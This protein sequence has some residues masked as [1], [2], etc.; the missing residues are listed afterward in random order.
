M[1]ES[2]IQV[3]PAGG[4][5]NVAGWNQTRAGVLVQ[6]QQV[7]RMDFPVFCFGAITSGGAAL[8]EHLLSLENGASSNVICRVRYLYIYAPDTTAATNEVWQIMIGRGTTPSAGTSKT[9]S[10]LDTRDILDANVTAY[11]NR[12]YGGFGGWGGLYRYL[13]MAH[14]VAASGYASDAYGLASPNLI[15]AWQDSPGF[16]VR[17]GENFSVQLMQIKD[18]A[19]NDISPSGHHARMYMFFETWDK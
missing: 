6:A 16:T 2:Y 1:T 14:P 19:G 18:T 11:L 8:N 12:T 9:P 13:L 7:A 15:P 17:P 5:P 10:P 4:G 3:P